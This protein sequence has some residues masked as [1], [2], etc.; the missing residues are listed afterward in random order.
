MRLL[1]PLFLPLFLSAKPL[2]VNVSSSHVCLMDAGTGKILYQK[3]MDRKIFPASVTKIATALYIMEEC[4]FDKNM[5]VSCSS[6]ALRVVTEK[7]KVESNFSLAPYLLERDGVTLYLHKGERLSIEELLYGLILKS[8]NDV[9]NVLASTFAPTISDFMFHLN[10]YLRSIGCKN[11]HFVNPH[12]LHHPDHYTTPHDLAIILQRAITYPYLKKIM[13]THSYTISRTSYSPK[14][15]I[16]CSNKLIDPRSKY[17]M[18]F[19]LGGKTGYHHRAKSNIAAF[20]SKNDR[21]IIAVVNKVDR[22][23]KAFDDCRKLFNAAF[24][25]KKVERVLFNAAES[26]FHQH[27]GWAAKELTASLKEDVILSYYPSE[28]GALEV[29]IHWKEKDTPI[30][31]GEEIATLDVYDQNMSPI[32]QA[33]VYADH[34]V[35]YKFLFLVERFFNTMIKIIATYPKCAFLTLLALFLFLRRRRVKTV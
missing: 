9:G 27:Y 30:E 18:P 10:T 14:R 15:E 16:R 5:E 12:G 26:K 8:S 24:E 11:T 1:L 21:E 29:K 3:N 20:G 35:S 19:V 4:S 28:E 13:S 6:E 33:S 17:F 25:E 22:R 34:A 7:K 2:N 23:E 32:Y 31:E